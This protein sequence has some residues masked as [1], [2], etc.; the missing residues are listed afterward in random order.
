MPSAS[1]LQTN[2][3]HNSLALEA[4][5]ETLQTSL[6]WHAIQLAPL[7]LV[8][9]RMNASLALLMIIWAYLTHKAGLGNVWARIARLRN[10]ASSCQTHFPLWKMGR[11]PRIELVNFKTPSS[12]W[13]TLFVGAQNWQLP[14]P[15][16]QS[17]Y[18]WRRAPTS[19]CGSNNLKDIAL[20]W[21]NRINFP[22]PSQSSKNI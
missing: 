7:A 14:T 2:T 15:P 5:I 22:I 10:S 17:L 11:R 18:S 3:A 9:L 4:S 16:P 20:H 13:E 21:P 1:L 8:P 12:I 19:S 6:A